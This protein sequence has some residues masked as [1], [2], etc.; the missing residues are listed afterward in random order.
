MQHRICL[1]LLAMGLGLAAVPAR[2]DT[3]QQLDSQLRATARVPSGLGLVRQLLRDGDL[4]GALATVERV[5][6]LDPLNAE[7][8][9]LHASLL[10]RLDDRSGSQTEFDP[11]RGHNVPDKMWR[12]QTAPCDENKGAG[13]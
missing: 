6:I 5:I 3:P 4:T 9:L 13:Q 8:R 11:M 1:S 10:C 7:A 12:D 2:A